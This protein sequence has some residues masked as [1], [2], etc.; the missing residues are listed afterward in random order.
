MHVLTESAYRGFTRQFT[1]KTESATM[2]WLTLLIGAWLFPNFAYAHD[3]CSDGKKVPAWVKAACCGPADVHRLTM[4]NVHTA[5]WNE[6]YM[7]I[8]GYKEPIRKATAL[9]SEDGYVWIFYKD[10]V[11]KYSK[12]TVGRLLPF[13][14][15]G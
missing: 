13:R 8:D 9:P 6:D 14:A 11:G 12:R 3:Y 4:S 7:I 1:C 15:D 10:E 2:K 5:P